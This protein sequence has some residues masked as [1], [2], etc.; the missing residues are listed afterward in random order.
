MVLLLCKQI[1]GAVHLLLCYDENLECKIKAATYIMYRNETLTVTYKLGAY[2]LLRSKHLK[3]NTSIMIP[4]LALKLII[5][6]V[7]EKAVHL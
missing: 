4:V 7:P 1:K 6:G 2:F 3:E 5:Q